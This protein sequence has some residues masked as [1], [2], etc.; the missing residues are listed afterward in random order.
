MNLSCVSKNSGI[1]FSMTHN[2]FF[3]RKCVYDMWVMFQRFQDSV[4]NDV[5]ELVWLTAKVKTSQIRIL[6]VSYQYKYI[7][8]IKIGSEATFGFLKRREFSTHRGNTCF[9]LRALASCGQSRRPMLVRNHQIRRLYAVLSNLSPH[10]LSLVLLSV[11][12]WFLS[13]RLTDQNFVWISRLLLFWRIPR[14]LSASLFE[15]RIPR[16]REAPNYTI[17]CSLLSCHF[18]VSLGYIQ[19]FALC[20]V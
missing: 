13:L 6:G 11:S 9:L 15:W 3:G 14:P 16:N 7:P 10:F 8:I 5:I 2:L 19:N 18:L 12:Q 20:K 4:P 17:F 1:V